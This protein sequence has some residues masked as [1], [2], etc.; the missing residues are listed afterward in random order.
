MS[1]SLVEK[2]KLG[3]KLRDLIIREFSMKHKLSNQEVTELLINIP[4]LFDGKVV[5]EK[6]KLRELAD[7]LKTR[8][9]MQ[10]PNRRYLAYW[11]NEMYKV[12]QWFEV[13]DKKF[14]E[15]SGVE[16]TKKEM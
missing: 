11:E 4:E 1:E 5:V 3:Q 13:F 2:I 8:P 12:E 15:L 9:I 6:Q 7:L 10:R 14:V 16:S